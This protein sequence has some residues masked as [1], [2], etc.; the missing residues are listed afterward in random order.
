MD[1]FQVGNVIRVFYE[2]GS[3]GI[4]LF[5]VFRIKFMRNFQQLLEVFEGDPEAAEYFVSIRVDF[6][7]IFN[8]II[9]NFCVK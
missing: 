3:Y 8:R 1:V 2:V 6:M 7:M 4:D 5:R 9:I